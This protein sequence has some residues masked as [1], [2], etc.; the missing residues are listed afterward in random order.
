MRYAVIEDSIVKNIII[1]DADF[2]AANGF[3]KAPDEISIGWVYVDGDFNPPEPDFDAQW[4][5]IRAKRNDLLAASDWTQLPDAP[6]NRAAWAVYRQELRDI[7]EQANPFNIVWPQ[8]P[9]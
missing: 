1:A 5:A 2:A 3:I 4:A 7:T 9:E 6:V 8:A